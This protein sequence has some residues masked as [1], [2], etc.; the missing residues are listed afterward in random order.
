MKNNRFKFFEE[1]QNLLY[2]YHDK[3]G[4][5]I[6]ITEEKV[7]TDKFG[8]TIFVC[9][10]YNK[11]KKQSSLIDSCFDECIYSLEEIF[12]TLKKKKYWKVSRRWLWNMIK[13]MKFGNLNITVKDFFKNGMIDY[14]RISL[15]IHKRYDNI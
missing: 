15:E 6:R 3:Y 9:L 13:D 10:Y 4:I 7:R 14:N 1:D 8:K 11:R 12:S 2:Y 5:K